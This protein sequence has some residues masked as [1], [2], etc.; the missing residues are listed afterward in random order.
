[1]WTWTIPNVIILMY[2]LL[3][4]N[5]FQIAFRKAIIYELHAYTDIMNMVIFKTNPQGM[6]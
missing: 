2:R 4:L 1:M 3:F 6:I 5:L